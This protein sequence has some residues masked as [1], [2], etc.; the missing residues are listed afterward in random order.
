MLPIKTEDHW[1]IV[2]AIAYSGMPGWPDL[3]LHFA[4]RMP[5]RQLMI[6]KYA[7]GRLPTLESI[8][9]EKSPTAFDKLKSLSRSPQTIRAKMPSDC[10]ASS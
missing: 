10:C 9:F 2:R 8:S 1:F 3:L 7:S 4:D 5:T 6:E